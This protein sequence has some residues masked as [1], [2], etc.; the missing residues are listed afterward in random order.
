MSELKEFTVYRD[1]WLRGKGPD[2]S[3]L[4]TGYGMC[5]LGFACHAAG[6]PMD[7]LRSCE[8]PVNLGG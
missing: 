4:L 1:L 6:V 5:C 2:A 3:G 7:R 8:L